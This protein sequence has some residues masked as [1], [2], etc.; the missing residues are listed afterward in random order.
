MARSNEP[1]TMN[2]DPTRAVDFRMTPSGPPPQR[3]REKSLSELVQEVTVRDVTISHRPESDP[4]ITREID[5]QIG[6]VQRKAVVRML[7]NARFR[8]LAWTVLK[9]AVG[10]AIASAAYRWPT[11]LH[12]L[13][14][15]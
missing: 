11:L 7:R 4:P 1:A 13:H 9:I 10:G 12:W 14:L 6:R 2:P 3:P 15:R 8:A 5:R